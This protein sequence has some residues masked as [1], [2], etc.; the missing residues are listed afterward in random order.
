MS[1]I[2][3]VVLKWF[4]KGLA[5]L[6]ASWAADQHNKSENKKAVEAVKNSKTK[7]ERKDANAGVARRM[8]RR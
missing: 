7:Q 3:K 8:G 1:F 2:Q 4:L 5:K 6:L